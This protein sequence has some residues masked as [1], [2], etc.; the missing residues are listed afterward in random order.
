MVRQNTH[1]LTGNVVLSIFVRVKVEQILTLHS[2]ISF[3]SRMIISKSSDEKEL[4]VLKDPVILLKINLFYFI[5]Y[6][7]ELFSHTCKLFTTVKL[8]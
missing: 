2:K 5:P 4:L 3:P 8:T 1:A 6:I 7:F